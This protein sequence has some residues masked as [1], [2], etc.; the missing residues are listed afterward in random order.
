MD[1]K[2]HDDSNIRVLTEE[3]QNDDDDN[4]DPQY[5]RV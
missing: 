2:Q 4:A 1:Q 3:Y 5:H